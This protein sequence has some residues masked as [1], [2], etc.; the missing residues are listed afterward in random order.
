M[1]RSR[2]ASKIAFGVSG[3]LVLLAILWLL[4]AVPMLV[5]Y[6]DDLDASPK[7]A[8]T[9]KVFVDPTTYAPLPQPTTLPLSV[10]RHIEVVD[11]TSSK[12]VVAETLVQKAGSLVN[13]TQRNQYVMDRRTMKNVKDPR[14]WAFTPANVV[15]RSGSYRLNLPFDTKADGRYPI[16][17][18]EIGTTYTMHEA[19]GPDTTNRHGLTLQNHAASRADVPI[20]SAYLANLSSALPLPT[21]MTLDQ[22]KPALTAAGLDVDALLP[23]LLPALTQDEAATLTALAAQPIPLQYTLTFRGTASVEPKTGAEVIVNDIESIG[24]R[25]NSP[26]L[27]KLQAILDA[28]DDIPEAAAASAA[29][30]KLSSSSIKVVEYAF[31]QTPASIAD[32]ASQ[33][34]DLRRQVVL[35]KQSIPIGLALLAGIALLVGVWKWPRTRARRVPATTPDEQPAEA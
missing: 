13:T 4:V 27:P 9:F 35:A 31:R 34:K 23:A 26:E 1:A 24:I 15:D 21:E 22:L 18:N 14:A 5:K 19:A 6:P 10:S 16:Y 2:T 28:H 20:T 8:G 11:A 7:Y 3:L 32:I 12:A 17:K 25:P 33:V 30:T 29:L